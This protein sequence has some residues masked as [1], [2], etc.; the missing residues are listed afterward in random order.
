MLT[1]FSEKSLRALGEFYVYALADPRNKQVFY[2]GKGS[3]NR[4]FDH[5][6]TI[7]S[8]ANECTDKSKIIAEI[9]SKGLNAEKIIINS[10]LTEKEALA[11]EAALINAFN[12]INDAQLTNLQSGCHSEEA[13]TAEDFERENGAAELQESDI[14]HKIMIIKINRL[15][16]RGM[17]PREL[18][19]AVRGCWK[20]SKSSTEDVEYVL[21]VYHSLIV[22]VYKPARWYRVNEAPQKCPAHHEQS[23]ASADERLFFVDKNFENGQPPDEHQLFYLEKSIKPFIKKGAQSPFMYLTPQFPDNIC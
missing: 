15:Y 4:I 21:G 23:D 18:Y 10:N 20:A 2:I 11:A 22:G 8:N 1:E 17:T 6:K 14:R 9:K 5:E 16:R 12:F 19:D 3:G 13:I 7:S